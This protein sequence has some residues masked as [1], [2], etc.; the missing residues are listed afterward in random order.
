MPLRVSGHGVRR[1]RHHRGA[2]LKDSRLDQDVTVILA[3]E[4]RS[5]A[6]ER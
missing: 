6:E 3:P 1:H 2:L 5:R 4:P